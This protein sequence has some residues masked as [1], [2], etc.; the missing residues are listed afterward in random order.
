MTL[1]RFFS[2]T[3]FL[4]AAG[5]PAAF[6]SIQINATRVIYHAAEKD[7]S[8]QIN[9]PG[10]YP[11]L[12]QSWIDDGHPEIRPDAL[13]TPFILTPPL[14]RVNADAGQTLRLSW[15]GSP[16]PADRES[17][18]WLNVLE[19]PPVM[20]K[21]S[22]QIQ[23]AFRSRIKLFYRPASLDDKGAQTAI[24]KLRWR[25]Q[26]NKISLSN[27]TPYY[28]SAVAVTL[29]R[30]GKKTSVAADML[31]PNGSATFNLPAGVSA[32]SANSVTVDAINDYGASV[33]SPISQL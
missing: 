3:A 7:V 2:A 30:G 32:D 28:V 16:L 29:T 24:S 18:F 19:I 15:S 21:T 11:V 9:N 26:G 33:T 13:R 20:D 5:I 23:V 25:A 4:L 22:N 6:A 12:L 14:T 17:V 10:K 8:V 31:A 1:I 27:P